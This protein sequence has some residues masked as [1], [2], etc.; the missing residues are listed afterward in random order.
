[1]T[2]SQSINV[3]ENKLS[4]NA[5]VGYIHDLKVTNAALKSD[6]KK[7][8]ADFKAKINAINSTNTYFKSQVHK[9][10]TNGN[11]MKRYENKHFRSSN[12][13]E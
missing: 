9:L 12:S 10:N 4:I 7:C 2:F 11:V 5:L 6:L 8:N 3:A 13:D 1:M